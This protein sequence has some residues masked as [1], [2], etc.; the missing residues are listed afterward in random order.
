LALCR[1]ANLSD[2]DLG[3]RLHELDRQYATTR[4]KN[5]ATNP[6]AKQF[7]PYPYIQLANAFHASGY[8]TAALEVLV[9]LER[10]KTQYGNVGHL[11][12]FW[13]RYVLDPCLLYGYAPLRPIIFVLGW[14]AVSAVLFQAG[15]DSNQIVASKDNRVSAESSFLPEHA[16]IPFNAIVYAIDTLIP[17]VDLNQRKNWTVTTFS[18]F[19]ND[20]DGRLSYLEEFYRVWL[21]FPNRLFALLVI[22]N[23]FFGW[24]M[25]TLFVAGVSGLLRTAKDG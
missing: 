14:A 7:K 25:T 15:Y 20:P 9:R 24:L 13:R 2:A 8:E 5:A 10:N 23:T 12:R 6:A 16:R 19:S 18:S 3:W 21:T 11:R 22:F 4:S 17:I 1:H